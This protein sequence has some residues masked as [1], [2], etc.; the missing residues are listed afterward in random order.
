MVV[1]GEH[2]DNAERGRGRAGRVA[3]CAYAHAG[4]GWA[5]R[6]RLI[7]NIVVMLLTMHEAIRFTWQTYGIIVDVSW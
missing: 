7:L 4:G 5:H 6:D 3:G 1:S 2:D